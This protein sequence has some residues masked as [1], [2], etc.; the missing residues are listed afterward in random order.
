MKQVHIIIS[1]IVLSFLIL[2]TSNAQDVYSSTKTKVE[3]YIAVDFPFESQFI[4]LGEDTIHYVESGEGDPVLLLHGLPANVY[5]WRNIIPNIDSSKKVIAID[6]LGFGKSSFP[7]DKGVSVEEQYQMLKDFIEVKQLKN[8]TLFIQDIGSLVGMLYA[9]REPQNVK[10]IALF[11]APF[12]PAEIMYDQLPFSLK[13]FM[14]LTRS[15]EGNEKWMIDR[16]FAGKRIAIT[17]FS[18]RKLP[19]EACESYTQPWNNENRRYAITNGPDPAVLSYSKGRGESEFASLLDTIS[20]GMTETQVPILY[21]YARKGLINRKKAVEYAQENFQNGYFVYLG[22]GKHFLTES[23]PVT[24]SKIFNI[25][26][27]TIG[28]HVDSGELTPA[29]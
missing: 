15:E 1:C 29:Y 14:R 7:K 16:N 24:M 22:K 12:M 26:S 6:L 2:L 3:R 9:I 11:E 13:A 4:N 25:W 20:K 28:S 27:D 17:F 10:G 8:V 23:H 5:L 18:G 21:F 19:K